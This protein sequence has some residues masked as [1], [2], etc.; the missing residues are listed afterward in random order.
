MERIML[1]SIFY[2]IP[3]LALA[4]GLLL[5][6]VGRAKKNSK[7]ICVGIGFIVCLI[8]VEAPDFIDG[9]MKGFGDGFNS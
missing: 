2:I 3:A 1:N 9:F 7:L 4:I 8:V 6:V 5:Y